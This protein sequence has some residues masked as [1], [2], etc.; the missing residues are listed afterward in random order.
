MF[1]GIKDLLL[2]DK[3]VIGCLSERGEVLHFVSPVYINNYMGNP[4]GLIS[5]IEEVI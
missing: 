5:S 3:S 2:D 1:D 4:E